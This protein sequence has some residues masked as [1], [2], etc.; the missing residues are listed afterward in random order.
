M[1]LL[2][3]ITAG[4][5]SCLVLNSFLS[6]ASLARAENVPTDSK[7]E[8][9]QLREVGA[10]LRCDFNG[11]KG[12]MGLSPGVFLSRQV[13]LWED[14]PGTSRLLGLC[15]ADVNAPSE[16]DSRVD[17]AR[18]LLL[19]GIVSIAWGA[20]YERYHAHGISLLGPHVTVGAKAIA[21]GDDGIAQQVAFNGGVAA[22][23]D[24]IFDLSM[25][26]SRAMNAPRESDRGR[27]VAALG[28]PGLWATYLSTAAE[29][30]PRGDRLCVVGAFAAYLGD[31]KFHVAPNGRTVLSLGIKA[32]FEPR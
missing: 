8:R 10:I 14:A 24:E 19:P 13:P 11:D 4:S 9:A 17:F 25:Q 29:F 32:K 31:S 12:R 7:H 2:R 15:G 1:R 26:F 27:V 21:R 5:M 3:S 28:G 6:V 23:F 20:A 30:H 18:S 22:S 16:R